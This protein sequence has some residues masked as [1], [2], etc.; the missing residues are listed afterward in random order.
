[1]AP[2]SVDGPWFRVFPVPVSTLD[3]MLSRW[4]GFQFTATVMSI[5]SEAHRQFDMIHHL[6]RRIDD[7]WNEYRRRLRWFVAIVLVGPV[8]IIM[9]EQLLLQFR[10]NIE[11]VNLV[12]RWL[13]I[14]WLAV[15]AVHAVLMTTFRCPAC[16]NMFF[17]TW[18]YSNHFARRCVHCG[19]HKWQQTKKAEN[20]VSTE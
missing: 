14:V 18:W 3:A 4:P 5:H 13:A 7:P 11:D 6:Q 16:R 17:C 20:G 10:V 19:L 1:M 9:A 8:T 2:G 12:V 15:L